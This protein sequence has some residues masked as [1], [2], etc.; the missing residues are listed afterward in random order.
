MDN[1]RREFL[2][3]G[4]L[5][6]GA[7]CANASQHEGH[8]TE[9]NLLDLRSLARFV[10]RLPIPRKASPSGFVASGENPAQRIA[11][12]RIDI[13]Q[14]QG[15]V[16]R[17]MEPSTL[18]GYGGTS[19]GPT[20]EV[21]SGS[22]IRVEWFNHLPSKHLFTVD[23][24]LHGASADQPEVRTVVHLHGGKVGPES[25]GFPES[26][27]TPGQSAVH[28]YPNQQDPAALF[29]HDHAMGITRLNTA[30]GLMGLY[31]IR[32]DFEDRLNLPRGEFEVPLIVVDRSF[33]KDGQIDYPVSGDPKTPWVS[34]YY[35]GGILVN[36]KLFP[37]LDVQ[38]RRY[39]FRILNNSNSSFYVLSIAPDVSFTAPPLRFFQIG[40]DQGFLVEPAG[41]E[42]LILGPGERADV[43]V[44]FSSHRGKNLYLRTKVA[45]ILQ[46]RVAGAKVDDRSQLPTVLRPLSRIPESDAVRTRQLTLGDDQDRLGKSKRMLLNGAHWSMPVTEKVVLGSTEI[47]SFLNLTDESHP[48]HLH[49]VRFQILDRT[50]FDLPVYQLTGK[51]V[52]TG[53]ALKPEPG[54]RGWKDTVRVDPLSVTRIII[55]FEGFTGRYVWHC[56]L[57]EHEDNEMMRP[58]DVLPA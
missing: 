10:D 15:K 11:Q 33:R 49:L 50:P 38:P 32:D 9:E 28:D 12:Y 22:A 7:M 5:T 48:I 40:G 16:H 47:W 27:I 8:R 2:R 55:K 23:H 36:G 56:H 3:R 43:I 42:R 30:A 44:D 13:R 52:F 6:M 34:E 19:P 4:A 45:N 21:R 54:E 39:R 1:T 37:F 29:Y 18:W 26:W 14:F 24:T 20:I 53:P 46:F 25:D 58:Y 51:V 41:T 17:D 35:G 57:L 31:L